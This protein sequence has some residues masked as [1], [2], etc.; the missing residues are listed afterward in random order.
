MRISTSWSYQSAVNNMLNQQSNLNQTQMEIST[1]K[2]YLT[3]SGNPVVAASLI[4]FNEN[5]AENQQYQVNIGAAQASLQLETSSLSSATSTLQSIRDLTVQG[6]NGVNSTQ[7][8]QQIASQVD[9]L[10]QQLLGIANKQ[11]ANGD[12]V[13]SGTASR[14]QPYDAA[15]GYV[16]QGNAGQNN[17]SIGPNNRQVANG[18]PGS[19]V[20]GTV[21]QDVSQL[22]T[23]LKAG[24]PSSASLTAI[25]T[26]LSNIETVNATVG[27]R[28]NVLST[29]Q[30]INA[31][32]ILDNQTTS[33]AVGDLNYASAISQLDLQQ[34]AL[35]A[36]QQ[37]FT[38]VMGLSLFQYM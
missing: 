29:Q 12:Y 4:N 35:Q 18:D 34:T 20:F 19:S 2:S 26:A 38:K 9:Q 5:I 21:L 24:T 22:S 32:T 33:S 23:D 30:N 7:N 15:T 8:L 3:P 31:Q 27:A 25:D 6:L 10:N 16:Y 14:T 13:F 17:I 36:S 11:D 28:L 37:T 1:G